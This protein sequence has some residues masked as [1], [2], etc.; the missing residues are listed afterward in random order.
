MVFEYH[1]KSQ[2][3]VQGIGGHF[4]AN[5]NPFW[6]RSTLISSLK[7]CWKSTISPKANII[8]VRSHSTASTFKSSFKANLKSTYDWL[9]FLS[10]ANLFTNEGR[11]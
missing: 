10:K 11:I 5:E 3:L 8:I 4:T 6:V 1:Q 2:H 9:W 7:V